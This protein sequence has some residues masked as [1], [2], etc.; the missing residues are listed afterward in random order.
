MKRLFRFLLFISVSVWLL[1][2]CIT[3]DVMPD[4]RRGNFEALWQTLG[5]RYC[6]FGR[7]AA[8]YGLDC[9]LCAQL[10]EYV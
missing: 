6:F 9:A 7:K 2:A 8:A 3:E 1:S 5:E 10:T 4:T